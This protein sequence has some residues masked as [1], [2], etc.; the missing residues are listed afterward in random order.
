MLRLYKIYKL[1]KMNFNK[2]W[3]KIKKNLMK[4]GVNKKLNINN[5]LIN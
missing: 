1:K 4:N 2:K 3:N 5:I